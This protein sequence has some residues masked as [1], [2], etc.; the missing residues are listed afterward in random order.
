MAMRRM[1]ARPMAARPII[2]NISQVA[3]TEPMLRATIGAEERP[4]MPAT[5]TATGDRIPRQQRQQMNQRVAVG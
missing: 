5:T 1:A 3:K 2:T 4:I